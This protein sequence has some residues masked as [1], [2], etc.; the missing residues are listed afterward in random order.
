MGPVVY[1]S[2]KISSLGL[3]GRLVFLTLCWEEIVAKVFIEIILGLLI[4]VDAGGLTSQCP[5][6]QAHRRFVGGRDDRR[7]HGYGQ[8][9]RD[10]VLC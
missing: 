4:G 1:E 3:S 7:L 5:V 6:P 10:Q 9:Y 8:D 2:R